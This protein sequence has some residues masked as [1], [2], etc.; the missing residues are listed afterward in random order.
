MR[1]ATLAWLVLTAAQAHAQ[2]PAAETARRERAPLASPDDLEP[3]VDVGRT[4][5]AVAPRAS[6]PAPARA[7]ARDLGA[8]AAEAARAG[9]AE[10]QDGLRS[11][12]R[13]SAPAR[14]R[15]MDSID[16]G[17]TSIT[18]NQE[19]PKVLYIVPWKKSGLGDVAGRPV[20]TLLDEV[21]APVDP[22]VFQRHLRY[23]ETLNGK[24]VQEE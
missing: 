17:T 7:P 16:L 1:L 20:N 21:L 13:N 12:D 23:Y 3:A 18:G 9:A 15:T 24:Q 8:P 19:L 22:E 2:A 10:P 6:S 5:I 11:P 14:P 4:Q